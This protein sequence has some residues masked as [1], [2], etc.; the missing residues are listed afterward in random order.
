MS[1]TIGGQ[2]ITSRFLPQDGPAIYM[3][4]SVRIGSRTLIVGI[5]LLARGRPAIVQQDRQAFPGPLLLPGDCGCIRW[6]R[7]PRRPRL[8]P[9][10]AAGT[11][12]DR[13]GRWQD[14]AETVTRR[15]SWLTAPSRVQL[16]NLKPTTQAEKPQ[17][18]AEAGWSLT[19]GDYGHPR[20]EGRP[21]D[22]HVWDVTVAAT[23]LPG[24]GRASRHEIR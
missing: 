15:S 22:R 6:S 2:S 1:A 10:R 14:N 4:L 23:P 9:V 5:D 8:A 21:A 20:G 18:P 19:P 11:C 12:G 7:N 24:S 16:A 3:A 17:R 13:D